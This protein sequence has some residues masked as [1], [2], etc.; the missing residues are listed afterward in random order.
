MYLCIGMECVL[1]P[2]IWRSEDNLVDRQPVVFA[3]ST[4]IWILGTNTGFRLGSSGFYLLNHLTTHVFFKI[5]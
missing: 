3:L 1:V 2:G 5:S 4:F